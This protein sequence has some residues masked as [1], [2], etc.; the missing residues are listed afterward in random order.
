MAT[1]LPSS[2]GPDFDIHASHTSKLLGSSIFLIVLPTIFVIL[3]LVSRKVAGAGYWW[4]DLCILLALIFSYG[5]TIDI[6][7]CTVRYGLGRHIYI[8]PFNTTGKFM[9][10]LYAFEMLF[11]LTTCFNKLSIL[12]FYRRI[13]P[14]SQLRIVLISTTVVVCTFTVTG[15]LVVIFQ[16]RPISAFWNIEDRLTPGLKQCINGDLFILVAGS[17]NCFL[18]FF[19][20]LI[21]SFPCTVSRS[22][23]KSIENLLTHTSQPLPLLW[24]LRTTQ[25]QKLVLTSIFGVAGL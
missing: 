4:D 14:I 1:E 15:L 19:I 22:R 9:E 7:V 2:F 23:L 8:L 17:L 12:A 21:V 10:M 25:S 16:C 20:V 3:R 5:L 18:D 11:F 13:F 24:R 6:L